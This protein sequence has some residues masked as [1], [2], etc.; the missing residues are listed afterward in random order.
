LLLGEAQKRAKLSDVQRHRQLSVGGVM[1]I[2]P[3]LTCTGAITQGTDAGIHFPFS[4]P[5]CVGPA[6]SDACWSCVV[7]HCGG[8]CLASDCGESQQCECSCDAGDSQCNNACASRGQS[9]ACTT[10]LD[11]LEDCLYCTCQAACGK[12]GG[13]GLFDL[14]A[15]R[16]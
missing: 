1:L 3:M 10:C 7:G 5:S 16:D 13:A 9:T 6:F 4:G 2:A 12:D 8:A 15:C 14:D 11:R